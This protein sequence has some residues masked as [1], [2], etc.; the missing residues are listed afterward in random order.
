MLDGARQHFRLR[1]ALSLSEERLHDQVED[2]ARRH[3][4]QEAPEE[5]IRLH[6]VVRHFVEEEAAETRVPLGVDHLARQA[7]GIDLRALEVLV[8]IGRV[9]DEA[10]L[11]VLAPERRTTI[12]AEAVEAE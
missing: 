6:R 3:E 4:A 9:V 2:V 12:D 10:A 7:R 11:D 5:T 1:R 8:P